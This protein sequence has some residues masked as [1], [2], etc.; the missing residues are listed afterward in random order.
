LLVERNVATKQEVDDHVVA[1][2]AASGGHL[3]KTNLK[4]SLEHKLRLAF[5]EARHCARHEATPGAH[6]AAG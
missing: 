3:L 1:T 5:E 4:A 6:R 2:L